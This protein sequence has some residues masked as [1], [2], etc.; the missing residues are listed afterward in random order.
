MRR[1]MIGEGRLKVGKVRL[2]ADPTYCAEDLLELVRRRD[3]ELIVPTIGRSLV[4]SPALEDRRV[5]E[6]AA[7]HVVVLHLADT[8]HPQRLPRQIFPRAPAAL[9]ARHAGHLTAL[10]SGPLAP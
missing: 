3:L 5:P 8:L 1:R 4:G 7:L 9:A 10:G 6:A 2:K